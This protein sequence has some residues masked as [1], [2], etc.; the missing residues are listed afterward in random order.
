MCG[1]EQCPLRQGRPAIPCRTGSLAGAPIQ[2]LFWVARMFRFVEPIGLVRSGRAVDVPRFVKVP[3]EPTPSIS[4]ETL[5]ETLAGAAAANCCLQG[6]IDVIPLDLGIA[7]S[8]VGAKRWRASGAWVTLVF[9]TTPISCSRCRAVRRFF[10]TPRRNPTGPSS[11]MSHVVDPSIG[12]RQITPAR[13][14]PHVTRSRATQN[15]FPPSYPNSTRTRVPGPVSSFGDSE[16]SLGRRTR[17]RCST[18]EAVSPH[19]TGNPP[20]A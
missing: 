14:S 11:S 3:A 2:S 20:A 15:R 1:Q 19:T 9:W 4:R 10:T 8:G 12:S 17:R 16:R 7:G 13:W 6:R 5:L 18:G